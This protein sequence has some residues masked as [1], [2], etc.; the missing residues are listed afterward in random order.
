M[1]KI[2]HH[3]VVAALEFAHSHLDGMKVKE[4]VDRKGI[5]GYITHCAALAAT[6]GVTAGIGGPVT[7]LLG[8]PADMVNTIAQQF[9]VTLAVIYH[10]TGRYSVPFD[11]F[12]K[13]VG[14]SL[15]VK[16]GTQAAAYGVGVIAGQVAKEI[17]KRLSVRTA[18]KLIPLVG[19]VL[20]GSINYAF[21]K[22]QGKALLS[23]DLDRVAED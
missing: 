18:G 7:M 6:T 5:D 2:D 16:I 14:L 17:V 10:R 20:G 3:A 13:I 21:I 8:V 19:G 9:R 4:L 15:G 1:A 22:A 11:Q 12:I 23:L